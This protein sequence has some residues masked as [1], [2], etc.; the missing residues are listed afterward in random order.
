MIRTAI[1]LVGCLIFGVSL[2]AAT[3]IEETEFWLLVEQT[4]QMLNQPQPDLDA[5][6]QQWAAVDAVLVADEAIML[7][8]DW[9]KDALSSGSVVEI[10][11]LKNY[12]HALQNYHEQQGSRVG[13]G[14]SLAALE[15]VLNDPRF[16]YSEQIEP[17]P[18]PTPEPSDRVP[19]LPSSAEGSLP[20][21]MIL[22]VVGIIAVILVLS[23]IARSINVQSA[24]IKAESDE[25][26]LS[27]ADARQR[28]ENLEA[29]RDYRTAIRY[30]Y[31][32]SLLLLDERNLLRYDP[33]LTNREH[34]RQLAA[35][36]Q[37]FDA[38]RQ[39]I[40]TFEEVWY[41]FQAVDEALYQQ[42][43]RHIDQLRRLVP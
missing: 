43:R 34:L 33:S 12:L 31:L 4:E 32:S 19:S 35:A 5:L 23:Y 29:A 27:F 22:I 11:R 37:L 42:Y 40:N 24:E 7:D 15:Q 25:E 36:P 14:A 9:V 10:Q 8:L 38:L 41:G 2:A 17:T 6:R 3:P 39:V 28:A 30:L 1:V 13:G 26:P 16:Q 21:Q 18:Q 20:S